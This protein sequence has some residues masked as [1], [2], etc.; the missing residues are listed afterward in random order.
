MKLVHALALAG[1]LFSMAAAQAAPEADVLSKRQQ[2]IVLIALHTVE[3]RIDALRGELVR[4]LEN[5][6]TVNEVKEILV[7]L[8][9]Y[10]GFPRS[11]NAIHTFMA[12]LDERKAAG[13]KDTQGREASPVDPTIDRDAYGARVRAELAGRTTIAPPAGYQV[14]APAVDAH[15]KQHLFCDIFARDNLDWGSRELATI[16]ALSGLH[17]TAGQLRFHLNAAMNTGASV[18]QMKDFY[19]LVSAKVSPEQAKD[20]GKVLDTV[21]ASRA[22]AKEEKK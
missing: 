2:S 12:V 11:L 4:G 10:T 14:F 13:I 20:V 19:R 5:G 6:L 16:G 1:A 9:A 7:Q 17:G 18:S 3:G 21:L 22:K 15:L 8:Y